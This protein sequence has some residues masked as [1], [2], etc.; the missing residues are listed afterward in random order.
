M[1]ILVTWTHISKS[2]YNV[3]IANMTFKYDYCK[4]RPNILSN[5][6]NINYD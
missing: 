3:T 5:L 1:T 2:V 4:Y 6:G